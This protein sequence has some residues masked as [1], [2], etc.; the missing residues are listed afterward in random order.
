LKIGLGFF[1]GKGIVPCLHGV[2][3]WL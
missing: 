3:L 1:G 2:F